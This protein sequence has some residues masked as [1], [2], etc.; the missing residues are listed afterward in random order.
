MDKVLQELAV[1]QMEALLRGISFDIDLHY[2]SDKNPFVDVS[3]NYTDTGSIKKGFVLNTSFSADLP[4]KHED[5]RFSQIKHF[6]YTVTG[7]KIDLQND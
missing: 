3:M 2:G 7:P 1:L 5:E 6:I 4:K